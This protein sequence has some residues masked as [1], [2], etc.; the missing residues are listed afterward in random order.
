MQSSQLIKKCYLYIN[1][2]FESKW[3]N[4]IP[5]KLGLYQVEKKRFIAVDVYCIY[6]QSIANAITSKQWNLLVQMISLCGC[7]RRFW[8]NL[9][10][11]VSSTKDHCFHFLQDQEHYKT[12]FNLKSMSFLSQNVSMMYGHVI[13]NLTQKV[14]DLHNCFLF[15]EK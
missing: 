11:L 7:I 4:H 10:N 5:S 6:L 9:H 12:M 14:V 1:M 8:Y 3:T 13:K 2:T 15:F